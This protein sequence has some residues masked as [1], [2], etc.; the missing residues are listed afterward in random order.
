MDEITTADVLAVL[1]P[2]WH[3]KPETAKRVRQRLNNV[4][5]WAVAQGYRQDNPAGDAISKALP[6]RSARVTHMRSLPYTEVATAVGQGAILKCHPE[7]QA[8]L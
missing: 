7:R 4:M 2:I 3:D 5:Q 8:C 1:T 6:K